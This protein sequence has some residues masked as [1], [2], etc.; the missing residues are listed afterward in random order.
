MIPKRMKR[1]SKIKLIATIFISLL[2]LFLLSPDIREF[3]SY[4]LFY[5][6]LHFA[7]GH[8]LYGSFI[9]DMFILFLC[10]T[11]VFFFIYFGYRILYKYN[12][13]PISK[14]T[15]VLAVITIP[16]IIY[17]LCSDLFS[18]LN[19]FVHN[20]YQTKVIS[21]NQIKKEKHNSKKGYTYY[22][23]RAYTDTLELDYG[24]KEYR[25]LKFDI[26]QYEQLIK[27]IEDDKTI[28]IDRDSIRLYYLPNT[29][30]IL[31]HEIF[32]PK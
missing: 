13:D 19:L 24:K 21:L 15:Y 29:K 8:F 20:K 2:I 27:E 30:S 22:D 6:P 5:T 26:Y 4:Y 14:I 1:T 32:S 12:D 23:Y 28:N 25:Y 16:F 18:D 31:K 10:C 9:I 3:I 17:L 7:L 11:G